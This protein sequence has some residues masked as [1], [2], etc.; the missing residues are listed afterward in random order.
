M[1]ITYCL[2]L[3]LLCILLHACNARTF[4]ASDNNDLDKKLHISIKN[5]DQNK[6]SVAENLTENSQSNEVGAADE[7]DSDSIQE[8]N[9]PKESSDAVLKESAVVSVS[10]RVPHNKRGEQH[11]GFN[12][13]YSPP[14]THPPSHN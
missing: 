3:F 2:L 7:T 11:P 8:S 1:P 10:W 14:K 6:V 4:P 13:D 12:L 5:G 9:E